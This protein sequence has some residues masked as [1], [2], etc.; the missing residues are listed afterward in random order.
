MQQF[1]YNPPQMLFLVRCVSS[2][3]G[4]FI[5]DVCAVWRIMAAYKAIPIQAIILQVAMIR[6]VK[7]WAQYWKAERPRFSTHN[8]GRCMSR[9]VIYIRAMRAF[10]DK[11]AK[12]KMEPKSIIS[13]KT[14][15][16]GSKRFF[17]HQRLT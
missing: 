10:F 5:W 6:T 13:Q 9:G 15:E 12:L 4:N 14:K 1:P 2:Q 16:V 17:L 8:T 7:N 11:S 3:L